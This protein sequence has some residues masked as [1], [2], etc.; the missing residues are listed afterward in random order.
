MQIT[1]FLN[2]VC[3]AFSD[4]VIIFCSNTAREL[5]WNYHLAVF[6]PN[7]KRS[8]IDVSAL[9]ISVTDSQRTP[10]GMIYITTYDAAKLDYYAELECLD[11]DL[12]VMDE[13]DQ[14]CTTE[15]ICNLAD[16]R[17]EKKI[18]MSTDNIM[19]MILYLTFYFDLSKVKFLNG[20][21][22][23]FLTLDQTLFEK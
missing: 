22:K 11:C 9:T 8:I 14:F 5:Q 7:V 16:L 2:A 17:I 19:V 12:L 6:A 23:I 1:A 20:E 13:G 10:G 3:H 21:S 15:Q 4:T 18:V